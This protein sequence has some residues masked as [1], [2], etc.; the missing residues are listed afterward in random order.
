MQTLVPRRER[1]QGNLR[2]KGASGDRTDFLRLNRDRAISASTA[3]GDWGEA[4]AVVLLQDTLLM[5][6]PD[7]KAIERDRMVVKIL[8]PEGKDY[9]TPSAEF[10]KAQKLLSFHVWSIGPDGH[11]YA[12]KDSEYVEADT[13]NSGILYDDERVKMASPPGAD[14]GGVIAWESTQQ[15]PTYLSEDIWQFQNPVPAVETSFEIDLPAGWHQYAVWFRHD[16]IAPTQATL[17]HFRWEMDNLKGIDLSE[18]QLH[19]AWAALA[20]RMSV[21]FSANDI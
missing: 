9:A 16:A 5:V 19:P 6:Q 4:K 20:C 17:D 18:V 13:S 14:P 15:I 10:S 2:G 1:R 11:Y 7:G 21:H 3:K 12:M 8:L